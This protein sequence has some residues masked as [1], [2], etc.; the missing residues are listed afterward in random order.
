M[1][2]ICI[3]DFIK[4][5]ISE[6]KT[7]PIK[8]GGVYTVKGEQYGFST[9]A[10]RWVDAYEF[11]EVAGLYEKGIFI[12]IEDNEFDRVMKRILKVPKRKNDKTKTTH[13]TTIHNA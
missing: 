2:V 3:F 4:S 1:K 5:P 13:T 10:Q 7:K 9:F 8:Y 12:P 11:E 6:V